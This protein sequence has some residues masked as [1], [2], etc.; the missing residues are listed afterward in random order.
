MQ[1]SIEKN[2]EG[3]RVRQW[4]TSFPL[5]GKAKGGELVLKLGFQIMEDKGLRV[6]SSKSIKE[7][8]SSASNKPSARRQ[9]KSSFSIPSPR[10]MAAK[11]LKEI[12]DLN[13][14]EPE[15][16]IEEDLDLPEFEIVHKGIE[17]QDGGRNRE[18]ESEVSSEIMKEIVHDPIHLRRLSALDSIAKQIKALQSMIGNEDK[19][20]DFRVLDPEEE[21]VTREF[22]HMLQKEEESKDLKP[23]VPPVELEGEEAEEADSKIFLLDL[24]NGLGPVI[25][26]RDGG[27]LAAVNPFQIETSKRETPKLATQISKLLVLPS[28]KTASGFELFQK[29]AAIGVEELTSEVLS[30]SA[31]DEL[32]GKTA[33]QVA[34]EGIAA[35]IINGRTKEGASSSASRSIGAV[36]TMATAMSA[37]RKQRIS[38]G[39]WSLDE[40][41]VRVEEIL[42]FA[43][44]KIEVMAIEALKMQAEV[45]EEEGPSDVAPLMVDGKDPDRPFVS[46][47]SLDEW[48]KNGGF[49]REERTVALLL[50]VQL[51]DPVRSFEAVGGRLIAVMQA[52]AVANGEEVRFRV[53]SL[54]VGGLKVRDGGLRR[55]GWD[56]EKQRLTAMQWLVGYG[57]GRGGKRGKN[58]QVKGQDCLWSFSS[59]AMA[60]M[61][62]N[63]TRN[64]D[65]KFP[66]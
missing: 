47:V 13:L 29:M 39:I 60:D 19:N 27:Y 44:Q 53:G 20:T 62:L 56:A 51:R 11:E 57:L 54:H 2:S 1:E 10:S 34:F 59:Q 25:Q 43:L 52:N 45:G 30:A 24:A 23:D 41:A 49:D 28:E 33:E 31:M 5:S 12:D 4:E 40:E 15:A 7:N 55:K 58:V 35:A 37:G 66:E 17:I 16:K 9:S 18:A 42:A 14:D 3:T 65:I 61:W 8:D 50:V 38:T 46:A 21:S 26:T 63:S 48:V 22:L 6:F 32:T 64:P 36:K